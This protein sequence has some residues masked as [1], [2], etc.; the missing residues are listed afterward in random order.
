MRSVFL[1]AVGF[2]LFTVPFSA[3]GAL[4]KAAKKPNILFICADDLKPLMGAYRNAKAETPNFDR[5]AASGT[6]FTKAVCNIP[7]CGASRA[8]IMTGL[9]PTSQRFLDWDSRVDKDAAEAADLAGHL[10]AGGY[11]AR[12]IGKILHFPDDR[13]DSWSVAPWRPDYPDPNGPQVNWRDYKTIENQTIAAQHENG[14]ALPWEKAEVS[15]DTYY[16]GQIAAKAVEFLKSDEAKNGPFFLGLGFLK[17]HLPFNAPAK[18]WD[19][20][21]PKSFELPETYARTEGAPKVA[22]HNFGELRSYY[23]VPEKGPLPDAM[24]LRLMHGYHACVSY[25]DALLGRVLD[26]LEQEHLA[27]NTVIV[28]WGDHGFNLGDHQLWCKHANFYSSL[29]VPLIIVDPRQEQPRAEVDDVV[30]LIDV[31]PTLCEV[32]GVAAP[33]LP[34]RSL[35]PFLTAPE[36]EN[37]L[38]EPGGAALSAWK[39]GLTVTTPDFAF[40]EWFNKKGQ[41]WAKMLFDHRS[42]QLEAENIAEEEESKLIINGLR[43]L[44]QKRLQPVVQP[45]AQP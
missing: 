4:E 45:I 6:T 38:R 34:G 12:N 22:Y 35:V 42:N 31:F 40:T 24:A 33:P 37:P 30:E 15:D 16:D 14:R 2:C 44:R 20:Y 25:V 3:F 9:R 13:A 17:P 26:T 32:A 21:D 11:H 28:L 23:G 43:E 5:L 18:Y 36:T 29:Q 41:A 10:K 27:E 8:S 19:L 39:G 7:V 1:L